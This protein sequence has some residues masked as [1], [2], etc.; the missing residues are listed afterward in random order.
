[1]QPSKPWTGT[2]EVTGGALIVRDDGKL[3]CL[4]TD[5]DSDFR[6]YLYGNSRFETPKSGKGEERLC[7]LHKATTGKYYI[8]LSLQ[9]RF[10]KPSSKDF[11]LSNS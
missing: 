8:R 11:S 1:M 6:D 5:R 4:C 10:K 9:I 3:V 7:T 2:N